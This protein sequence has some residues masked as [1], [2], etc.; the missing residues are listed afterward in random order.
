M[1]CRPEF[2]CLCV[3]ASMKCIL[4]TNLTVYRVLELWHCE[5]ACKGEQA[6]QW[7][8]LGLTHLFGWDLRFSCIL[9]AVTGDRFPMF[10]DCLVIACCQASNVP[11][12]Q[13]G[14]ARNHISAISRCFRSVVRSGNPL[15]LTTNYS[16]VRKDYIFF[17]RSDFLYFWSS[18]H[19]KL[20]R[21]DFRNC[22]RM[23]LTSVSLSYWI[24]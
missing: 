15:L 13:W 18:L 2:V 16:T 4:Q 7:R 1:T 23:F 6:R 19:M 24:G 12:Y 10:H 17:S 3:E 22:F 9:T 21:L 8:L 11:I 20:V 14:G 5:N